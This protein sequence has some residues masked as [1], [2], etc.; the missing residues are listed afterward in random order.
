MHLGPYICSL[1]ILCFLAFFFLFE[2][3]R[4]TFSLTNDNKLWSIAW[5]TLITFAVLGAFI[6]IGLW[7]Y[8]RRVALR[9]WLEIAVLPPPHRGLSPEDKERFLLY[10]D[11]AEDITLCRSWRGRSTKFFEEGTSY[12]F[13]E[14]RSDFPKSQQPCKSILN[15]VERISPRTLQNEN[16][17][18]CYTDSTSTAGLSI[19][20]RLHAGPDDAFRPGEYGKPELRQGLTDKLELGCGVNSTCCIC[21]N[22]YT[23]SQKVCLLPCQHMYHAEVRISLNSVVKGFFCNRDYC[24]QHNFQLYL[25]LWT[26]YISALFEMHRITSR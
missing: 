3:W 12:E 6:S 9:H 8:R 23:R 15:G 19:G 2:M 25:T 1:A 16:P 18:H 21:L 5:A 7:V 17:A 24:E 4:Y 14:E 26:I 10:F 11:W 20:N 13:D 22:G